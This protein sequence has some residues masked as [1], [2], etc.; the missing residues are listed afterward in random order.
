[1]SVIADAGKLALAIVDGASE[2]ALAPLRD[3][4]VRI[5]RTGEEEAGGKDEPDPAV[6]GG[7]A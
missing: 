6:T 7:A 1:M 5:E 4:G 2:D 3:S